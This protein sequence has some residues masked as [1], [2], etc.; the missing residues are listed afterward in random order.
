MEPFKHKY[1]HLQEDDLWELIPASDIQKGDELL[2]GEP[3]DPNREG[4]LIGEVEN[5]RY[6]PQRLGADV[7][8]VDFKDGDSYFYYWDS[9]VYRIWT[10]E[11]KKSCFI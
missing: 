11:N 2:W 3:E 10:L 8:V 1:R 9:S 4:L 5:I 7:Y 6:D